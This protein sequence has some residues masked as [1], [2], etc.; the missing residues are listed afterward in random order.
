MIHTR[1]ELFQASLVA[2]AASVRP[3]AAQSKA[4]L[5][6]PGL[7]PGRVI[8]AHHPASLVSELISPR[9]SSR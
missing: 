4:Q 7:F 1:R 6:M 5:G 3:A 9:R 2:A 8:A